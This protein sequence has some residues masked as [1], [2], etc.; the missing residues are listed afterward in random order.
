VVIGV[1][2]GYCAG[3]DTVVRILE[4]AGFPSIDVDAVGHQALGERRDAVLDA[5]GPG[6]LD[7]EGRIDRR[8]LGRIVFGDAAALARLESIVHPRMCEVV[9]G[10][11]S[12]L[13]RHCV[14]NAAI[15]YR[16]GLHELCDLAICVRAS[17]LVRL[18]RARARDGVGP[19]RALRR[20]WAQ[21][22]ICLKPMGAR[23]DTLT[24]RNDG[25]VETLR[26]VVLA[27]LDKRR[28]DSR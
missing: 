9:A 5:F 12:R 2:G 16:M 1:A 26:R 24:V 10:E 4:E 11:V 14:V 25:S 27:L 21:R 17:V 18:V 13:H 23:V 8:K 19:V 28:D 20:M 3:K 22:G 15:L 7:P 6:V